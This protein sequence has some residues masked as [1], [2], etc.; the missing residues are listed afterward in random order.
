MI[1]TDYGFIDF[2]PLVFELEKMEVNSVLN[3]LKRIYCLQT[4]PKLIAFFRKKTK[5]Y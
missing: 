3:L 2:D 5:G 1:E 4:F